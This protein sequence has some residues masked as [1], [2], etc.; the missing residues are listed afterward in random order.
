MKIVDFKLRRRTN[1]LSGIKLLD[2]TD[3]VV[4]SAN[5]VDF[6]LDGFGILNKDYLESENTLAEINMKSKILS[7][8]LKSLVVPDYI[9][10]FKSFIEVIK[11]FSFSSQMIHIEFESDE[12]C[13]IGLVK[14]LNE[15]SFRFQELSPKGKF[16]ETVNIR[17][18]K[19][20]V[21]Y[22]KTDYVDSLNIYLENFV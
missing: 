19:I 5:P 18:D 4:F 8:K 10:E 17:Y 11:F 1:R 13:L 12:Y 20:R 3:F 16:V 6:V 21:I 22:I 15:K 9:K 2:H 7:Y 14:E